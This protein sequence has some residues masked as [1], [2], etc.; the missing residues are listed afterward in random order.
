MK[1]LIFGVLI[2]I[3][4]TSIGLFWWR[5]IT[6]HSFIDSPLIEFKSLNDTSIS[7]DQLIELKIADTVNQ[8]KIAA[9]NK[10]LDD[11][12]LFAGVVI[13]LFLALIVGVYVK[14]DSEV[15]K[16]FK[17]NAGIYLTRI[18]QATSEA[19]RT[20]ATMATELQLSQLLRQKLESTQQPPE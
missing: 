8:E 18:K 13:T 7:R 4:L 20:L 19:E 9:L 6:I 11:Y 14:T 10:R 16:H 5:T 17:E 12:M 1:K 15:E 3:L 2:G